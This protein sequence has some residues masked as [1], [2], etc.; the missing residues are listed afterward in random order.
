M[1]TKI[2]IPDNAQAEP[3]R[4]DVRGRCP[5]CGR[6][7]TFE[8]LPVQDL[9]FAEYR[10]GQRR[11]PNGVCHSHVFFIWKSEKGEGK[12]VATFPS[13]K[14]P[15]EK[16]HIP[17]KVA[18]T[19]EEAITCHAQGCFKAAPIMIRRTLEEICRDKGAAGDTLQE[20]VKSLQNVIVVPEQLFKFMD[21]LRLLRDDAAYVKSREYDEIGKD[22]AEVGI[23]LTRE[24]LKAV[25]QYS[26]LIEKLKGLKK[27]SD[28]DTAT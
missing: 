9:W 16:A 10:L 21:R 5:A 4:V 27:K 13:Q 18:A 25:Y 11:C 22:E 23:E 24:I 3:P 28:G 17:D 2:A 14:V 6:E 26:H 7:A 8:S 12:V 19:F 20:R 1:V 15:F